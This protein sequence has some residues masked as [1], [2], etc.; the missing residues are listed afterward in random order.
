MLRGRSMLSQTNHNPSRNCCARRVT[1]QRRVRTLVSTVAGA[2]LSLGA[3]TTLQAA[4]ESQGRLPVGPPMHGAA[5]HLLAGFGG[6]DL[7]ADALPYAALVNLQKLQEPAW[8]GGLPTESSGPV[9]EA[10][11]GE[12]QPVSDTAGETIRDVI[13]LWAKAWQNKDVSGYLAAY[14]EGFQPANGLGRD[15]WAMLRRQRIEAKRE[16]R[17]EL[18]EIA[19]QPEAADRVRVNFIQDYRADQYIERGTA[20]SIVLALEK[21]GWRIVAEETLP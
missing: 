1:H 5:S 11:K 6:V 9:A 20:K 12:Q 13:E 2:L 7:A 14:G 17:L 15:D 8:A 4:S 18:R 21:D 16:I 3:L 19:I 10:D